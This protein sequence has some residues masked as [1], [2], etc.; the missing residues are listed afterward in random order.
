MSSTQTLRFGFPKGHTAFAI[1]SGSVDL[2][3]YNYAHIVE[4][5]T[6]AKS[7]RVYIYKNEEEARARH[8]D[9]V[10]K[11][12]INN[13]TLDKSR[14][15]RTI[16]APTKKYLQFARNKTGFFQ[17]RDVPA[18]LIEHTDTMALY[19]IDLSATMLQQLMKS[20]KAPKNV[21]KATSEKPAKK[22]TT[23]PKVQA[24]VQ[25]QKSKQEPDL[26]IMPKGMKI[27]AITFPQGT[28]VADLK[29]MDFKVVIMDANDQPF[30]VD[31][32]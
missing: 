2:T 14:I 26:E 30:M 20:C 27:G 17:S 5:N 31:T 19:D 32:K 22:V 16:S 12:Y 28:T 8:G 18:F 9:D 13:K 3:D 7:L 15:F 6:K 25:S 24:K 10:R 21:T 1:Y 23:E 4:Q 29:R 11:I